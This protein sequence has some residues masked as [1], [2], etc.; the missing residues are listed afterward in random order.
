LSAKAATAHTRGSIS[1]ESLASVMLWLFVFA[2]S[3]VMFEPSPYEAMFIPAL[4]AF[5]L[6]GLSVPAAIMP[7]IFLLVLM[8]IGGVMSMIQV[9]DRPD[10]VSYA[11]V[12]IFMAANAIFFA[13]ILSTRTL[14]R[15]ATIRGA[16]ILSAII[17][18]SLGIAGYFNIAGTFDTFT[19]YGRAKGLFKDPNVF[20]PFL[21]PPL[22]FLL[23]DMLLGRMRVL[24]RTLPIFILIFLAL[25]LGFSR[26]A[27]AQFVVSSLFAVL[28]LLVLAPSAKLRMRV[29]VLSIVAGIALAVS[30][31]TLLAVPAIHELFVSRFALAQ[32]YDV[33]AGGRFTNQILGI[34]VILDNPLGIGPHRFAYMFGE[35]PHNVYMNVFLAYGWLGGFSYIAVVVLTWIM[36]L[37]AM[38]RES[39]YRL[40]LSAIMAC[41]MGLCLLGLII[42]TDHWRH[43][44]LLLG[45]TW[46]F[47][48]AVARWNAREASAR[49]LASRQT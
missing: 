43:S 26:G 4:L 48:V 24:V 13:M 32:N 41:Y 9:A 33:G 7:L 16:Y 18:A 44:F 37:R 12:S 20:A 28:F 11:I 46:G 3:F 38:F 31:A 39:P 17:A 2:G 14:E 15:F 19:L 6:A 49:Q 47:I 45:V 25:F 34:G 35:D 27:W 36:G 23:Q 42:H 40:Q 10:T 22:I 5:M 29:V 30:L 21:I 1:A 8:N